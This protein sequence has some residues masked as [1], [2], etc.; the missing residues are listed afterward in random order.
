ME[1]I[2]SYMKKPG[3]E[4][5]GSAQVP[6]EGAVEGEEPPAMSDEERERM[7][8]RLNAFGE[9]L[10]KTR[11]EA[12]RARQASGIED[13]WLEDE[14]FYHGVDDSNRHEFRTTWRRKPVGQAESE[15]KR[16]GTTQSVVFPNI[17]RPYCDAAAARIS[18]MLLPT[19]GARPFDLKATPIPDQEK[20]AKGQYPAGMVQTAAAQNPGQPG[21]AKQQLSKV[22]EDAS[23][24]IEAAKEKAAKAQKRIDDWFKECRWTSHVRQVIEDAAR[25]GTGVL[26][27]PIPIQR[28]KKKFIDGELVLQNEI[29]P[30]SKWVDPWNL[31]PDAAC[32]EN[33]HN[34]SYIWERDYV[35]KKQLKDLGEQK[36]YIKEQIDACLT[37]GP[38]RAVAEFKPTPELLVTDEDQKNRF[39]IWYMHGVADRE[40]V[41]AAGCKCEDETMLMPV[42]IVMVNNRVIKVAENPL[43]TGD[44]PY[45]V[46]VWQRRSG[47]WTG[48][49]VS[50]QIRTP[51]RIVVAAT[52]NLMDNAGLAAGPM[53]VF[54]Q[55]VVYPAN[56]VAGLGPRKIY[57]I[58]E[59]ADE[60]TDARYAIGVVK[61]D[62]L[63]NELMQI[64]QFGLK[65]A[66]DVTG[67]PMLLQGQMGPSTRGN[68]QP[69]TLG[70]T[71][72]LNTNASTVLR[73][74]ARLFDDRM[75]EPHV[76]RYYDWLLM[77]G[78]D[79]EK[80]DFVLNA[81]GSSAL[82]ERDIQDQQIVDMGRLVL[83]P[84]FG[85]DPKKWFNEMLISQHFD[86]S[87]FDYD[88]EEWK[89]IVQNMKDGPQDPRLQVAE[90]RKASED[91]SRMLEEKL[92]GAE[93]G[94]DEQENQRRRDWEEKDNAL[95]RELELL[96]H[97]LT[98]RDERD[99]STDTLRTS[100]AEVVMKVR[101]QRD[102]STEGN[103]TKLALK[104]PSEPAG[105]A[106]P[107]ESYQQ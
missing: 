75:T 63:V 12:I 17:T 94:F 24:K 22:S 73:R 58:A 62:M 13:E 105:R 36:A 16:D 69:N 38:T 55:G 11:S 31:F 8:M 76:G 9:S 53:I 20:L 87:R 59:D 52:R 51:Q 101:A 88:D 44:Y 45:D 61:V 26:K 71:Q 103:R 43:E 89:K 102:L 21:L 28:R 107:G 72:I 42:M 32:G 78:E 64:I 85:K 82:V 83:D 93:R 49:G 56:G 7:M 27:G 50:R 66:E 47:H 25:I 6:G 97:N 14:E 33:I 99:I 41:M 2:S 23:V 29:K 18:D 54:R 80:G 5:D 95:D 104:P 74:M 15:K 67:L 35:T 37:E 86:P 77:H 65:L 81:L 98:S 40:D 90:I 3:E 39:E 1:T 34:G 19:G 91:A 96:I 70:Q 92:A 10:A 57:Y 4:E 100:L 30:V 68:R 106:A 84:R 48:I 46:M 79:D 60:M